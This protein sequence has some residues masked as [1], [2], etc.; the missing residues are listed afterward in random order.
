MNGLL[1][2]PPQ[3]NEIAALSAL[4]EGLQGPEKALVV[5]QTRLRLE[6]LAQ[7]LQKQ[8]QQGASPAD[9]RE[10]RAVQDACIAAL[11][12]IDRV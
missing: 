3:A 5:A 11:E 12:L 2:P 6:A 10:I 4:E 8:M 1:L 7:R 9:F